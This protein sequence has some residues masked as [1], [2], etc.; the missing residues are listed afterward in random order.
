MDEFALDLGDELDDLK[1]GLNAEAEKLQEMEAAEAL[2]K[3]IDP[4][5]R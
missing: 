1:A 3:Q 5:N 4:G 2:R